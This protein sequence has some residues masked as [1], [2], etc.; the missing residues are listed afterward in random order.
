MYRLQQVLQSEPYFLS[1]NMTFVD[2]LSLFVDGNHPIYQ[3]NKYR[4][5]IKQEQY[6]A[7]NQVNKRKQ[8]EGLPFLPFSYSDKKSKQ[9]RPQDFYEEAQNT[10]LRQHLQNASM[11]LFQDDIR[12]F[13]ML[14]FQNYTFVPKINDI[15]HHS[16]G[17][18]TSF[19]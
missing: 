14:L 6:E 16:Y 1:S 11:R 8:Q 7:Q 5:Q 17:A 18:T 12:P 15:L 10:Q 19:Y 2:P 4:S 13:L 9:P 3:E